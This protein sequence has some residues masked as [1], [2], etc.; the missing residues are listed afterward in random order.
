MNLYLA[1]HGAALEKSVDPE[2]PLSPEG[3]ADVTR[4]A[5]MLRIAGV[6]TERILHSG[7]SRADQ[8]AQLFV[9]QIAAGVTPESV[10]GI[11]PNDPVERFSEQISCWNADTLICGHQPFLG[12]LAS[13]LLID[14]PAVE[15]V[16]FRPGSVAKLSDISGRWVLCWFLTP[17]LCGQARS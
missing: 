7:K 10:A 14:D 9:Q 8:T 13:L 3:R 12:R 16:E 11:A 2:R 15:L 4:V 1:Q 5:E 6:A 17:E